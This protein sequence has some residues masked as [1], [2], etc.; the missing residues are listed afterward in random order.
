MKANK[1]E[2]CF[3]VMKAKWENL[4][5]SWWYASTDQDHHT[6]VPP[7]LPFT[8]KSINPNTHFYQY[9]NRSSTLWSVLV[10]LLGSTARLLII[11]RHT[12]ALK[13]GWEKTTSQGHMLRMKCKHTRKGGKSG[14]NKIDRLTSCT[15]F[16]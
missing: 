8:H 10:W 2:Q 9:D 13:S 14:K 7:V 5:N 16:S 11:K 15:V 6:D 1:S 12:R 4:S 3:S